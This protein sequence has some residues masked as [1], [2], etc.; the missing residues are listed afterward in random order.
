MFTSIKCVKEIN[1]HTSLQ[2]ARVTVIGY[3]YGVDLGYGVKPQ[4]HRIGKDL[5]C[6]CGLRA[7]CPAVQ[8]ARSL[9]EG[10]RRRCP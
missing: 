6:T 3:F 5:I 8:S 4:H 1:L 9:L 10:R 2:E 7:D